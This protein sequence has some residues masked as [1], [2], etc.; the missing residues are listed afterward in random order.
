[1]RIVDPHVGGRRVLMAHVE[2]AEFS[3]T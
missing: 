3:C 2:Y 1:V